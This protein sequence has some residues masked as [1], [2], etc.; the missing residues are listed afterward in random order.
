MRIQ[1]WKNKGKVH[2]GEPDYL[3]LQRQRTGADDGSAGYETV[4]IGY[5]YKQE[6]PDGEIY[7]DVKVEGFNNNKPK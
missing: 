1:V 3:V 5:G 4:N 2:D 6:A 7:L